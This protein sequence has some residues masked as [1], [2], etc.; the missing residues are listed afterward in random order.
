MTL[1][2]EF[3]GQ[4]GRTLACPAQRRHRIA[5]ARRLHEGIQIGKQTRIHIDQSLAPA[6]W[7]PHA[8]GL[9]LGLHARLRRSAPPGRGLRCRLDLGQAGIDGRTRY[10][11]RLGHQ[12]HTAATQTARFRRR[13]KPKRGL[14]K[15]RC[16]G[17]KLRLYNLCLI[18]ARIVDVPYE[19]FNLLLL[20]S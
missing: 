20:A 6:S 10:A 16:K 4:V 17:S 19:M 11:S 3:L 14:V 12:T 18:H 13:P 1:A 15:A 7:G 8:L 9:P 2:R 5:S